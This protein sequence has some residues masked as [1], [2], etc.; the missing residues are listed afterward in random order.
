MADGCLSL[1][2]P[3]FPLQQCWVTSCEEPSPALTSV[4]FGILIAT[5]FPGDPQP[6]YCLKINWRPLRNF[7]RIHLSLHGFPSAA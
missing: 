5:A 6:L 7:L 3:L 2:S 4:S 1:S